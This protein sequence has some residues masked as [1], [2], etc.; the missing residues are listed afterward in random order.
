MKYRPVVIVICKDFNGHRF[1]SQRN[2]ISYYSSLP[3]QSP[4]AWCLRILR[5]YD[6][7]TLK[8]VEAVKDQSRELNIN[9]VVRQG[10][11]GYK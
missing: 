6:T 2:L 9:C 8:K 11:Y 5:N 1:D 4:G 3:L 10:L 7:T